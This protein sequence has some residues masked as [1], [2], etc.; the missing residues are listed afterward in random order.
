MYTGVGE[1]W[2]I[3]QEIAEP[4]SAE[5][6]FGTALALRGR[7]LVV[8]SRAYYP[9]YEGPEGYLFERGLRESAWVARATLAGDGLGIELSGNTVMVDLVGLRFGTF[10]TIV[11]LPA[12]REPDVAP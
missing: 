8:N 9:F 2:A 4:V 3:S 1:N 11:N 7:R 5:T 10:P 6:Q 12:L